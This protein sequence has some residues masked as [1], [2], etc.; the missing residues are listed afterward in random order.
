VRELRVSGQPSLVRSDGQ[1]L[2]V[3][4]SQLVVPAPEAR[5]HQGAVVARLGA[6]FGA[7]DPVLVAGSLDPDGVLHGAVVLGER[8]ALRRALLLSWSALAALLLVAL[9][10]LPAAIALA[11]AALGR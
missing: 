6:S 5:P 2:R 10:A 8:G 1:R 4:P 7:G 9:A 11:R 3:S